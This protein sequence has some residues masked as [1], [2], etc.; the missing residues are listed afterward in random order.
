MRN[1]ASVGDDAAA[2]CKGGELW[3]L[4]ALALLAGFSLR[5]WPHFT[6]W[7]RSKSFGQLPRRAGPLGV[8]AMLLG[9]ELACIGLALA[10]AWQAHRPKGPVVSNDCLRPGKGEDQTP[11]PDGAALGALYHDGRDPP[12]HDPFEY[13]GLTDLPEREIR[14]HKQGFPIGLRQ[15]RPCGRRL[16]AH[17][18]ANLRI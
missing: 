12:R 1:Q 13:R 4:S 2:V 9:G 3:D 18:H 15:A 7:L 16:L 11:G 5:R 10:A 17:W 8:V 14:Y 6:P